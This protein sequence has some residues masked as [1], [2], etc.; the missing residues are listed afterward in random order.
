MNESFKKLSEDIKAKISEELQT[1][2][3][4][5]FLIQTKTAED[6]GSFEVAISTSDLDRDGEV[7][8][9]NGWDFTFYNMNPIVLWAHNYTAL[10]IGVTDSLVIENGKTIARGRFAPESA[11]PFAQQ[12]RRLYDLKIVQA[13]SVGFIVRESEGKKIIKSELLEFSFVPVP[14][15]PH[16]VSLMQTAHLNIGEF[17]TKGIL[18]QKEDLETSEKQEEPQE[19]NTCAMPD[20]TQGVY[21]HDE[22]TGQMICAPNIEEKPEVTA[23]FIRIPIKDESRYDSESIRTIEISQDQG[24]KALTACPQGE[25]ESGTCKVGTEIISYLFDKEK[26]TEE[27]ARQWVEE[28]EKAVVLVSKQSMRKN[29]EKINAELSTMQSE[30]DGVMLTH[31]KNIIAIVEEQYNNPN[32]N[33]INHAHAALEGGAGEE[34]Q[35]DGTPKQRS[36]SAGYDDREALDEFLSQRQ[37]LRLVNNVTSEAL[38]KLNERSHSKIYGSKRSQSI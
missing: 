23:D 18:I 2:K 14:A 1:K 22:N 8:D 13:V 25:Y 21:M 36:S 31:A 33:A 15:N 38:R 35:D 10:P 32:V 27:K 12:V 16:A 5:D 11:N 17:V 6:S 20:G 4:Q 34:S 37:V 30:V 29:I 19:G 26:W 28:H 24:I 3:M 7:I 9:Q